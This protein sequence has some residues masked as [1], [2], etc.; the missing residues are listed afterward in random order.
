MGTGHLRFEIG[1]HWLQEGIAA[2]SVFLSHLLAY[3]LAVVTQQ[4][5][6]MLSVT[7]GAAAEHA[8]VHAPH[9]ARAFEVSFACI[10]LGCL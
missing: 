2:G 7:H 4:G 3:P 8:V 9:Y 10:C 5:A 1:L 6:W